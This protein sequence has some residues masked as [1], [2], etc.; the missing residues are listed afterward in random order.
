MVVLDGTEGADVDADSA[1][2]FAQH[3]LVGKRHMAQHQRN[4]AHELHRSS[5]SRGELARGQR[6]AQREAA[7][8]VPGAEVVGAARSDDEMCV[9]VVG[10]S[11]EDDLAM[12]LDGDEERQ[13]LSKFEDTAVDIQQLPS[14]SALISPQ[15]G[16]ASPAA[17]DESASPGKENLIMQNSTVFGANGTQQHGA[18]PVAGRPG[19][20]QLRRLCDTPS[21]QTRHQPAEPTG[22]DEDAD[23]LVDPFAICSQP[24]ESSR[25]LAAPKQMAL[26]VKRPVS[27]AAGS[28]SDH[29]VSLITEA[30]GSGQAGKASVASGSRLPGAPSAKHDRAGTAGLS[31]LASLGA[32][33]CSNDS[34]DSGRWPGSASGQRPGSAGSLQQPTP[35][36]ESSQQR[37]CGQVCCHLYNCAIIGHAYTWRC[38]G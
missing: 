4:A 31:S 24:R 1:A 27:Q 26:A 20:K 25:N 12:M 29:D 22:E 23:L 14:I 11:D 13:L 38:R 10:D 35:S 3:M 5:S 28:G 9:R 19:R 15:H 33:Q 34:W 6:K 7:A 36:P 2:A 21:M 37:S 8:E 30:S 32:G 17:S 16:L 18:Q